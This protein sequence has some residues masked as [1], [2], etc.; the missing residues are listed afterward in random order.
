[1]LIWP[2][3]ALLLVLLFYKR[4]ITPPWNPPIQPQPPQPPQPLPP[5][6]RLQPGQASSQGP[7]AS[8]PPQA[9][10][11]TRPSTSGFT[12]GFTPPPPVDLND[13]FRRP[14]G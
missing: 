2:V 14:R 4:D 11:R 7:E 9:G 1:M 12:G 13:V 5:Q 8:Q 6:P 3:L 10:A